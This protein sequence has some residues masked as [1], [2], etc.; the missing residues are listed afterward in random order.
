MKAISRTALLCLL[1]LACSGPALA[2]NRMTP[3]L[4][5]QEMTMK[6]GGGGSP[7]DGQMAAMQA[8]LASMPPEKR[9]QMEA[10]MAQR[11]ISLSGTGTGVKVKMCV[12]PEQAARD[13]VAQG[14]RGECKQT[15]QTRSGNTVKV[16]VE[17]TGRMQG[18]GEGE[19]TFVSP[20]EHQG[21]MTMNIARGEQTGTMDMQFHAKW[22]AADCGDVKPLP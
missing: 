2:Q 17:C 20:K 22:L 16:T 11:G 1:T 7:M 15:S 12:T 4:W 10:M 3:G 19:F 8:Q 9:A 6:G 14:Q 18:R 5:E 21:K 13:Q